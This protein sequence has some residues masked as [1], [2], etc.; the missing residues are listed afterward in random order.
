MWET[1]KRMWVWLHATF[2]D[3]EF[4]ESKPIGQRNAW[5]EVM[6][7]YWVETEGYICLI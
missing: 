2:A 6:V 4:D 7:A 1:V 3:E 5:W